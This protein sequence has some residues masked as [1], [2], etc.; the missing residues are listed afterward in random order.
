MDTCTIQFS[1]TEE[2]TFSGR[3]GQ[4]RLSAPPFDSLDSTRFTERVQLFIEK[5]FL[6]NHLPASPR[7]GPF[8][9]AGL[10]SFHRACPA[11]RESFSFEPLSG[12]VL[13]R[14]P[15]STCW[16]LLRLTFRVQ[17]FQRAMFLFRR[18]SAVP[19]GAVSMSC[20]L[21]SEPS[22]STFYFCQRVVFLAAPSCL[23]GSFRRYTYPLNGLRTDRVGK[24]QAAHP[25]GGGP[26]DSLYW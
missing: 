19:C 22:L 3:L 10:Y 21:L 17:T 9:L 23:I 2:L 16:S 24:E 20:T 6:S 12:P 15:L 13:R 4:Q 18:T 25:A 5:V 1:R 8:R 11:C 7:G 26:V 14:R